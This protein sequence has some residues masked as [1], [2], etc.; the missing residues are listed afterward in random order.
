MTD[1]THFADDETLAY[2]RVLEAENMELAE[3]GRN[4]TLHYDNHAGT[5]CEQI[6]HSQQVAE[7]EA[8]NARLKRHIKDALSSFS[9]YIPSRSN[10][11]RYLYQGYD[12]L[13]AA[14][15]EGS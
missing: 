11:D 4:L 5:P 3:K 14:L 8:E 1:K 7:L 10:L 13:I 12:H 6:R 9:G 2:I 15:K